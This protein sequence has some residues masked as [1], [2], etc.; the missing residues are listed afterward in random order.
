MG[1]KLLTRRVY[2]PGGVENGGDN[3][4]SGMDC[5]SS[6]KQKPIERSLRFLKAVKY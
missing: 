1:N 3:G 4:F 6:K 5:E 2:K